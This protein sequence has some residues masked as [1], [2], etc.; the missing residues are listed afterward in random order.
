MRICDVVINSVWYDPRVIKQIEEYAKGGNELSVVGISDDRY[1]LE[2]IKKLKG[3]VS[4]VKATG[5]RKFRRSHKLRSFLRI[6]IDS[7]KICREIKRQNPEIIHANDLNA[8]VPAYYASKHAKSKLIYD[9]HEVFLENN[10][11][12]NSFI[13]R[14]FWGFYENKIIRKVDKV[15]CVSHAAAEYFAKKYDIQLPM[16][17]THGAREIDRISISQPKAEAF[18]ILNHG[19]FYYGRGYDVMVRAAKLSTNPNIV[20]VLRGF[21]VLEKELRDYVSESH[22][23]NV[24]FDDPVKTNELINKAASSSV[25]VAVTIPYCLNFKLS[26]SNKLFEYA[27]AGLP[28][29]MSDVPEHRYLNNKYHFG[30]ILKENTPECFLDAVLKLYEDKELYENCKVNA[31]KMS[32]ELCWENDFGKLLSFEQSLLK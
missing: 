8:L 20:F 1:N 18:E 2:E 3:K 31:I 23:E 28:V 25:G 5:K 6:L 11:V 9:T 19:Q 29:I 32:E 24:R 16:V 27:A 10:N 7:Y 21:G 17:V 12:Y 22:I 15:V 4:I 14:N 30:I 13:K 26:V